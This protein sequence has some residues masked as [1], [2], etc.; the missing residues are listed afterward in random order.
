MKN[1]YVYQ[2][3][4]QGH[5]NIVIA[6]EVI[7]F[8]FQIRVSI[9]QAFLT[10]QNGDTRHALCIGKFCEYLQVVYLCLLNIK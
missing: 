1:V 6:S 5:T 8:F 4:F 3:A 9:F 10:K 2:L 7:C